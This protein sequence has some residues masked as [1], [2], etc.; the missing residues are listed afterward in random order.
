[1]KSA[2]TGMKHRALGISNEATVSL[3][4]EASK[5]KLAGSILG[6]EDNWLIC[7]ASSKINCNNRGA[8]SHQWL[9]KWK[10]EMYMSE[11][12]YGKL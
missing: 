4:S 10:Y 1:M 8:Q 3:W 5:N 2:F 12:K 6:L 9:K 7:S 11:E